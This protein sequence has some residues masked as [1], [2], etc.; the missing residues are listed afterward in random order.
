[1]QAALSQIIDG[2]G[3]AM[4]LKLKKAGGGLQQVVVVRSSA[5]LVCEV[6]LEVGDGAAE[7]EVL[8]EFDKPNQV[9]AAAAAMTIEQVFGRV[10]IKR[11]AGFAMPRTQAGPFM[12]MPAATRLPV[13]L[14][15]ELQQRK[16]LFE[17]GQPGGGGPG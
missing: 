11:R 15:Q 6:L 13:A 16:A 7:R 9:A 12:R 3:M 4:E 14:A 17:F 8:A 5:G 1:M 2:F 10:D